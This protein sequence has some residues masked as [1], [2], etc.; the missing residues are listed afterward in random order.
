MLVPVVLP[1]VE[2]GVTLL[3]RLH[4]GEVP[5]EIHVGVPPRDRLAVAVT[6]PAEHEALG[7]DHSVRTAL[8]TVATGTKPAF[9]FTARMAVLCSAFTVRTTSTSGRSARSRRRDS[10][11]TA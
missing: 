1:A 10:S 9:V 3:S 2:A 5:R 11:L 4:A 7:L 6:K 8:V